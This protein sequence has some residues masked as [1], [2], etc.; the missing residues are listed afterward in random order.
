MKILILTQYF[1]PEVGAAQNRLMNLAN[2]L[3]K[4]GAEVTI[5]TAF[6]NYPS[7]KIHEGYRGRFYR[8]ESLN[9]LT[10]HRC[11]IYV[12]GS[13][14]IIP[15]LLNYFSFVF[16]S[17]FIGWIKLG[18][19]DFIICESPPLFLGIS[20]YLLK[21]LKHAKFIFNVSDLWPES[22]EKLGLVSNRFLLNISTKLEEFLYRRSAFISGQTQGIVRNIQSRF[23][24]KKLCWLK[25][26]I[27]LSYFES[28]NRVDGKWR[29]ENGYADKEFLVLYAGIIGH[30]QG[31]EV[32]LKA[33]QILRGEISIRF[34]LMGSGPVKERLTAMKEDLA[35]SNVDFYNVVTRDELMQVINDIDAAVIPL[36]RLELF[37]GAIPSKIFEI[38]AL[39]KPILLG[40]EGEAE[41]LFIQKGRAGLAFIPEDAGDLAEKVRYLAENPGQGKLFGDNGYNFVS[42]EFNWDT[43][44]EDFWQHLIKAENKHE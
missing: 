38:L 42:R 43:I 32:I 20:G 33:A 6:P 35:L 30:A 34:I 4:K 41:E 7:M 8:K 21:K 5:L 29:S 22:A 37:R 36:L 2:G 16:T 11:W 12:A 9:G 19:F 27:D 23:P 40:V 15:R 17:F 18:R 14:S 3:K 44:A 24:E 13:K 39:K 31:L 1:P 28:V 26:G 25:N 10:V